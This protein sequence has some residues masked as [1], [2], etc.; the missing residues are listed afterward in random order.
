MS[1]TTV[2]LGM[3]DFA[4]CDPKRCSGAK[5]IRL[6]LIEDFDKR[7]RPFRGIVLTPSATRVMSGEDVDL[8]VKHGLAVVD[9]SWARLDEVPWGRL[10]GEPRL[11]PFLVAA[12]PV[13]YGKPSKLNCVEALLAGLA[14]CRACITCNDRNSLSITDAMEKIAEPFSY[15]DEFLRLNSD[16]ITGYGKCM[17]GP[18]VIAMQQHFLTIGSV[19]C[20]DSNSSESENAHTHSEQEQEL[21]SST[22]SEHE[23]DSLGNVIS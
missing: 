8:I 7:H 10:T 1:S 20:E 6:G 18:E 14:I 16:Y 11:L 21:E 22:E 2:R 13:N 23:Y 3:W 12:N 19:R 15:A 17:T 9:C 5:L 4:Q